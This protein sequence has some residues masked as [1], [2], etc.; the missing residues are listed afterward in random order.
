MNTNSLLLIIHQEFPQVYFLR[1]SS[2]RT[3]VC[4]PTTLGTHF[5]QIT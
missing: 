5:Y 2:L 3:Q 4:V 1:K